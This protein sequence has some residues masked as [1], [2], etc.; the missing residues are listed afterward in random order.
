[1]DASRLLPRCGFHS[2]HLEAVGA[3]GVA[4]VLCEL[5]AVTVG[6]AEHRAAAYNDFVVQFCACSI[7][8]Q[9]GLEAPWPVS[10]PLA[11]R[12]PLGYRSC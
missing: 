9:R 11:M 12:S 5:E 1:M 6:Q 4:F 3:V 8:R 7:S 10:L 2:L